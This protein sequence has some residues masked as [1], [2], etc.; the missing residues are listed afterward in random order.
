MHQGRY[1]V[2]LDVVGNVCVMLCS[3]R[4]EKGKTRNVLTEGIFL[5]SLSEQEDIVWGLSVAWSTSSY[6]V[7]NIEYYPVALIV[8]RWDEFANGNRSDVG[9]APSSLSPDLQGRSRYVQRR[10]S[11][12]QMWSPVSQN[13]HILCTHG[14]E[15]FLVR[16]VRDQQVVKTVA[17]PGSI[18]GCLAPTLLLV[19]ARQARYLSPD[20][21]NFLT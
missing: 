15:F 13:F 8:K 20:S 1:L 9:L 12:G 17:S 6:K 21:Y 16:Y 4:L 18:R 3:G 10:L 2:C 5:D 7:C 19:A 11:L 14:F